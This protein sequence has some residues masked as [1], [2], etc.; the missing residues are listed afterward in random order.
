MQG[1][2]GAR[3][4]RPENTLAAFRYALSVPAVSTLE[5]DTGI[6]EDGAVVV[7]HDRT[8]NGSHCVDTAPVSAGD[9]EFPY[10]GK[11]VRDLSLA[12]IK[13]L[14]CGSKTLAEFPRQVAVPGERI[15]TLAEVFAVAKVRQD[16][17]FNIETKISPTADDTAPYDV[18]TRKVVGE[19]TRAG[20]LG[21][22][23]L[24]SFD[25]RTIQLAKRIQPRLETVALVWQYGPAECATIADECSLQAV[26]GNPAVKS[27]WTGGL[28]WWKS[29]DLATLIRQSGASTVSANWQVHDPAQATVVNPDWYLRQDPSY[30]HGPDVAGLHRRG[31]KA[32]PYTVNDE[33]TLQRVIDLGVDGIISD[34]PDLLIAVAKRN[35]LR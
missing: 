23:T 33:P 20:V 5:L 15:P 34:D 30:F 32:I 18:F 29:R 10:V 9:R 17:R 2:R 3:A 31:L 25:W 8:I 19:I 14:D 6:T 16:I 26:Y 12:Q 7:I 21:R 13:T 24:Q 28:D 1:H 22:T 35:G 11:R 4:V 27:P